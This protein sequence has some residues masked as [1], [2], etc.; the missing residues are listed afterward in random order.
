MA[1]AG[2]GLDFDPDLLDP[3]DA[4]FDSYENPRVVGS[5][6]SEDDD[7][8]STPEPTND[9]PEKKDPFLAR[10]GLKRQHTE[11]SK[12]ARVLVQQVKRGRVPED[13]P[14]L[15]VWRDQL[16]S[17]YNDA[18]A[19]HQ[20]HVGAFVLSPKGWKK[21]DKWESDFRRDHQ[22][23]MAVILE[24]LALQP[25]MSP[26]ATSTTTTNAGDVQPKSSNEEQPNGAGS[27]GPPTDAEDVQPKSSNPDPPTGAG[28]AGASAD[29][30]DVKPKTVP[31]DL[32][33]LIKEVKE[34]ADTNKSIVGNNNALADTLKKLQV[35]LDESV[36][37]FKS[38]LETRFQESEK[39]L[40]EKIYQTVKASEWNV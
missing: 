10:S 17:L 9:K 32:K 39:R 15:I 35:D 36:K 14:Q 40:E 34:I 11:L 4:F 16:N 31:E 23:I 22:V 7:E 8:A 37:S 19:K 28:P 24:A 26:S 21:A 20:E 3:Q 18:L 5:Q 12:R 29:D 38:N 2:K 27:T 30:E 25:K 1:S 13:Y 33:W 6:Q